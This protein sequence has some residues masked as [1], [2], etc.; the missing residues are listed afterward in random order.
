MRKLNIHWKTLMLTALMA[1]GVTCPSEAFAAKKNVM[2]VKTNT[3]QYFPVVRVSMMVVAD[4]A[5]TFE[6]VLKDGEGEAGVQSISFEKH[7]EDID[8]SKYQGDSNSEPSI[9]VSKKIHLVTSTGKLF[10]MKDFPMLEAQEGN[11]LI[12]VVGTSTTES[13]VEYVYFFRG[14]EE[15]LGIETPLADRQENLTLMTPVS[16]QLQV[17]GCGDATQ[18]WVYAPNGQMVGQAPVSNGVCTV[19]VAHLP[20]GTYIFKVGQKSLKFIKK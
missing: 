13:G 1:A 8:F 2:C 4:G 19:S 11:G 5:S 10:L 6:I 18:A 20:A 17:S 7:E 3:G 15:E 9:D 14:N 16:S 12:N